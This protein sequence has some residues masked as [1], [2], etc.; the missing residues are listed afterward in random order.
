[1]RIFK[2]ET[3][4]G[5]EIFYSNGE[6][7]VGDKSMPLVLGANDFLRLYVFV[8]HSVVEVYANSTVC[9]TAVHYPQSYTGEVEFFSKGNAQLNA[10]IDPLDSAWA[11]GIGQS[12]P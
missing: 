11:S 3:N 9:F 7:K 1:M 6:L 4:P 8:D 2:T 10:S 12:F 5:L